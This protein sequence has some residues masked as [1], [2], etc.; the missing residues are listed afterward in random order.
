[1]SKCSTISK[2]TIHRLIR[3]VKQLIKEPLH[4]NGIYYEHDQ[5]DMLKGYAMI[6]GPSDTPYYLSLIHI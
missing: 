3:D 6:V 2:E 4:D 1:M 5:E